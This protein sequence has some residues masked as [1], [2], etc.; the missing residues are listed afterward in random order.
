MA[1]QVHIDPAGS[2]RQRSK[3]RGAYFGKLWMSKMRYNTLNYVRP[4]RLEVRG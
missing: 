2:L 1:Q 4:L 3:L